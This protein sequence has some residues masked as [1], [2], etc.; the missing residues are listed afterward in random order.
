[1][2]R[3]RREG[4]VSRLTV[5]IE[6]RALIRAGVAG[7]I[8]GGRPGRSIGGGSCSLFFSRGDCLRLRLSSPAPIPEDGEAL[9]PDLL[10]PEPGATGGA[11]VAGLGRC[12]AGC[13]KDDS[14]DSHDEAASKHGM[15]HI[16]LSLQ[17]GA[18]PDLHGPDRPRTWG[19]PAER[20]GPDARCGPRPARGLDGSSQPLRYSPHGSYFLLSAFR[21]RVVS[22]PRR[23][24]T[25]SGRDGRRFVHVSGNRSGSS[26]FYRHHL[27]NLI[28]ICTM[29]S[30]QRSFRSRSSGVMEAPEF[31]EPRRFL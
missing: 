7:R 25:F 19:S 28:S 24:A 8:R 5:G 3:G 27:D 15:G 4:P 18:G 26:S 31:C 16:V 11:E 1:M 21:L 20:Q 29:A 6:A 23:H 10:E 30:L 14:E 12:G 17:R 13:G 9:G 22:H 2:A